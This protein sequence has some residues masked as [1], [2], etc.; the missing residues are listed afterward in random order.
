MK[1]RLMIISLILA[2]LIGIG[3]ENRAQA[4]TTASF[5]LFLDALTPYTQDYGFVWSPRNVGPDWEPYTNGRWV[6][7]R[8]TDGLG[9]LM[10]HGAGLH[11]I[12]E[13][14]Y[15]S[16]VVD[17]YGYQPPFGLLHG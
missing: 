16:T 14:G 7:G 9:F 8:I 12:M 15:T 11:F 6:F 4:Y 2:M 1:K 10:N 17:G 3:Y 13:G 5:N